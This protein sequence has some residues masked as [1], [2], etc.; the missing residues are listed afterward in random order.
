MI[1][2]V[3]GRKFQLTTVSVEQVKTSVLAFWDVFSACFII[4]VVVNII[5]TTTTTIIIINSNSRSHSRVV[6]TYRYNM[7]TL[8]L[9]ISKR[10]TGHC[11]KMP[12]VMIRHKY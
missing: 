9:K 8:E 11:E 7:M 12:L 6:T 4:I 3:G 2:E 5:I 1:N 10:T